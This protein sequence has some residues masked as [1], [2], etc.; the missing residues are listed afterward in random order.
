[1]T[2]SAQ[3]SPTAAPAKPAES[4]WDTLRFLLYIFVGAVILR[5]FV[6][7]PFSIPSGSMLPNLMIGDYLFVAKWPYG[8]SQY[9]L[10]FGIGGFSGR[11][12]AGLPAR[13][14]IIVFRHPGGEDYVKRVIGLP[15]DTIAVRG[16]VVILNGR[17]VPRR[18]IADFAMPI[19]A[20]S[21]CRG[22]AEAVRRTLAEDGRALCLY[23]RY[24]E[25]LPGGRGYD[26]ID[27]IPDSDVDDFGP[28]AIP[29]DRLF[30]MGDNRDDSRDSRVP[31]EREGVGLLPVENVLGEA[32]IAFW[33]TDGSTEWL[34]P[35]TWFSAARWNRVGR[36]Y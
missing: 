30:V 28:V 2:D 26:V 23:P 21:P 8:Y 25:T 14:D 15:G 27:Q 6:I 29:A 11:V 31:V 5:S 9:S 18:R 33:S 20:N 24:R 4:W 35:W 3:P 12:P 22:A 19:S 16:G 34:K 10:P 32:A 13:G 1:M 7:A 17:P 36:S